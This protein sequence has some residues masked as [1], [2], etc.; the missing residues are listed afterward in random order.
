MTRVDL[1]IEWEIAAIQRLLDEAPDFLV[2]RAR[3]ARVSGR[4]GFLPD[5]RMND[6]EALLAAASLA[7]EAIIYHLNAVV[8][9][10]LLAL[11]TRILPHEWGLTPEAQARSRGK[12]VSAIENHYH[13]TVKDLPGWG[14]VDHLREEANALK[15]R[16][17]SHLPELT[18]IGVPLFR[19]VDATQE[20]LRKRVAGT[21]E[22]LLNLWQATEVAGSVQPE[23]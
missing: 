15:H 22:W 12:L 19:H 16:G 7:R 8:D 17:G 4:S 20:V 1:M 21:R 23:R 18:S 6:E 5:G 3:E 13:L 14:E 10:F 9:W 11:A 2:A